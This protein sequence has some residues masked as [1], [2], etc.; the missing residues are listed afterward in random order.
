MNDVRVVLATFGT[1]GSVFDDVA[2]EAE[3]AGAALRS[4]V[5]RSLGSAGLDG[6]AGDL[7]DHFGEVFEAVAE[8]ATEIKGLLSTTLR[9]FQ[10]VDELNAER[11][12]P[13]GEPDLPFLARLDPEAVA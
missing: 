6:A 12:H 2:G 9:E 13:L 3:A 1:L 7:V 10:A 8:A 4:G 11:L 5:P